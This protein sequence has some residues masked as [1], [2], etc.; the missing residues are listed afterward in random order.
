VKISDRRNLRSAAREIFDSA[1]RAVDSRD[2][3]RRALKLDGSLLEICQTTFETRSRPLFAVALGKAAAAMAAGFS[4]IL[5]DIPGDI[6]TRGVI[7]GPPLMADHSFDPALW[8]AFAGGHPVPNPQSLDAAAATF[9]LLK[10][11]DEAGGLVVFLI[12]GGGSAMIEWP[13]EATITLEDLRQA[14]REL[15]S[16]G[17]T[18]GEINAVRRTFSAVKGGRLTT[19]APHA[20]HVTLIVSDTNQGD[21]ANVASGPTLPPP[22]DAPRA[23]DVIAKYQLASKLPA[24]ILATIQRAA[25]LKSAP[26]KVYGKHQVL[27]DNQTAL[28]AA[29]AKAIQLGFTVETAGDICEQAIDEGSNLL[30][31]RLLELRRRAEGNSVCLLSGGEFSCRVR[32]AGIG[33]RNLETALRLAIV[34]ERE[35]D[36]CQQSASQLAEHLVAL[37]AGTDGIDGNSPAAGA[38]ADETS[39]SR[40]KRLDRD[41][42][43]FLMRSDSF[44]FFESLGDTIVTGSTGTN[45]RDLRILLASA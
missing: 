16:C 28:E 30:A 45:V 36:R 33:G 8:R 40:G 10:Q 15:I 4:D 17:A 1:L 32:G 23:Q 21:E 41:A 38:I 19:L 42:K 12:S 37:C 22:V 11:A 3:T 39:I 14:N 7:A 18:I 5:A 44:G 6:V 26:A 24:S 43:S 34:F 20:K 35:F 31:S 9:D 13:I 25:R 2:A 29:A 27:L